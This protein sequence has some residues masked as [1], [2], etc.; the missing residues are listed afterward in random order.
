MPFLLSPQSLKSLGNFSRLLPL[1]K[2]CHAEVTSNW[3]FHHL[4][5][6][7]TQLYL[8]SHC[9]LKMDSMGQVFLWPLDRDVGKP[10]TFVFF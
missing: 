9:S 5:T 7:K 4:E 10:M 6:I 8:I 2:Y 1:K 3:N